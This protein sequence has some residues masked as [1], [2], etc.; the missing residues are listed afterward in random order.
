MTGPEGGFL[1]A[2]DAETDGHEGAYYTWTAD[3]LD[4]RA[5]RATTGGS[6]GRSTASRAR[7]PS[8][9][10]ATSSTCT[11][12]LA[13]QA[14]AGGLSE[15]ELLRRLEPGRRA[16]LE[17]RERARAPAHR[18]QGARRLERP[19]DRRDG[20]GRG[21]PRRAAL[22]RGRE[23]AAAFVL[24]A[25]RRGRGRHAPPLATGTGAPSVPAF[26]DDYAFLVEGLLRAARGH[27]REALAGRGGPARARSRSVASATPRAAA[28]SRRARTQRLL[29]R[30]KP[31]FDGAVA[32]GNGIAALNAVELA[33]ATGDPAWTARAEAAAPRLRRGHGSR[34]RSRTSRSSAPWTASSGRRA[35]RR[36]RPRRP[37]RSRSRPRRPLAAEALEE[38]AYEAR[39][40][41]GPPRDERGRRVEAVPRG[42]RGA[43]GLA[44][45]RPPGRPRP[46]GDRGRGRPGRAAERALSGG[47]VLGRRG[48][49]RP[50]LPGPGAR[51]RARSS[52]AAAARPASRSTYQACDDRRCLPAGVAHRAP[53]LSP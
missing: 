5:A 36:R 53:A 24:V 31:A 20:P 6:S 9:A 26:L 10:S 35:R 4:A 42:A 7:R 30:A 50:G 33:R 51:S 14:R 43:Q 3:E 12:P 8:R 23:R 18:R 11:A 27:R 39:R 15:A 52:A 22:R 2:I 16:L 41:R 29:V 13:E 40:D 34:R 21:A 45:E 28:G 19:H 1:S 49:A 37:R 17:A 38:E 47:R 25:P 44:R 48:R 46:R 32:S